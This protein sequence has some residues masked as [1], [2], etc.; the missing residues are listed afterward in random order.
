MTASPVSI[1]S[2]TLYENTN[3]FRLPEPGIVM[4][5]E[6]ASYEQETERRVKI[7]GTKLTKAPYTVKLEGVK[8]EGYRRVAV[9]GV[10]DPLIL[11]QFDSWLQTCERDARNKIR[12]GMGLEPE[13]YRL[14]HL[15]YGNPKDPDTECVGIVFDIIA[16]S[17]EEADGVISNV[18]HTAL[19]VPIRDWEGAQ[20]QAG[21]PVLAADPDDPGKRRD[22]LILSEPRDRSGRSLETCRFTYYDL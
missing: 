8:F 2:H 13:E 7:T 12:A 16:R 6:D 17:P 10:S 22:L 9:A 18:W 3:P 19:H 11:K 4:E 21:V 14:R 5:T 20:S 15:V 1:V